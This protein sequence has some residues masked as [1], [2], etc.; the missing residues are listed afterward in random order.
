MLHPAPGVRG[1][2]D[3][4][5]LAADVDLEHLAGLH[6]GGHDHFVLLGR[7]EKGYVCVCGMLQ[8]SI[9]DVKTGTVLDSIFLA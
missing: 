9:T 3:L 4:H 6:A 8:H 1:T 2:R 7:H 5:E